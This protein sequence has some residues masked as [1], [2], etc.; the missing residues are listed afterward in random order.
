MKYLVLCLVLL[1]FTSFHYSEDDPYY[2]RK[3]Q[4]SSWGISSYVKENHD[5]I[6]AEYENRI[7]TLYDVYL[8]TTDISE[9]SDDFTLGEFYPP[10]QIVITTEEKYI[11]YDFSDMPKSKQRISTFYDRTVKAVIFHELTHAYF[12]QVVTVLKNEG[13]IVSPEYSFLRIYPNL[14]LRFGTTFI[15]EGV[16]EYV[17]YYLNES[18]PLGNIKIPNTPEELVNSDNYTNVMYY[19]SVYFL[20][21]FLDEHGIKRGI[22]ILVSNRP[23]EYEE[24]IKPEL[25]FN[26]LNY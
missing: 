2:N 1:L 11:A 18:A 20:K 16:C 26:R 10:D 13:K 4:P 8:W 21:D 19:Y 24:M 7:D 25:Y 9:M 15:E 22:E 3:K 6:I 17:V 23:P 5:I 12:N 14:G